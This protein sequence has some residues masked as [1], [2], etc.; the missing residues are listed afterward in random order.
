MIITGESGS[1]KT[2]S[3]KDC[4]RFITSLADPKNIPTH[5]KDIA[6]KVAYLNTLYSKIRFLLAIQFWK[7]LEMQQHRVMTM[8]AGLVR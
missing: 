6:Q 1:G 8:Q 7:L 5:N 3:A 4:L 2:V